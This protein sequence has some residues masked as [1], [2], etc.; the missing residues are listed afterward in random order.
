MTRRPCLLVLGV[1]PC[2]YTGGVAV[3]ARQLLDTR[4]GHRAQCRSIHCSE[5]KQNFVS[6][7]I[8][9][10]EYHGLDTNETGLISVVLQLWLITFSDMVLI[11]V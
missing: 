10:V 3:W 7:F 9:A 5:C 8:V 1:W 6:W 11:L 2:H 4:I